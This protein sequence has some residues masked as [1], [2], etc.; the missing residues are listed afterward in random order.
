MY[1]TVKEARQ[2]R[3]GDAT[4]ILDSGE[5]SNPHVSRLY[6]HFL[7]L[8]IRKLFARL[9]FS[10]RRVFGDGHTNVNLERAVVLDKALNSFVRLA[11]DDI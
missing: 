2:I 5:R 9:P 11:L 6:R 3:T 4:R 10:R 7:S 8:T 1:R